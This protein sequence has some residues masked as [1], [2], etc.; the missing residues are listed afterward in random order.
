MYYL[1]EK[2]FD[3]VLFF[4][5]GSFFSSFL[6][7]DI[8]SLSLEREIAL[9]IG[10]SGGQKRWMKAMAGGEGRRWI[11]VV[12]GEYGAQRWRAEAA[13]K[14]G[15]RHRQGKAEGVSSLRRRHVEAAG[16]SGTRLRRGRLRWKEEGI[17]SCSI[18]LRRVA[19]GRPRWTAASDG[20]IGWLRWMA[21]AD[22]MTPGER[23]R[24]RE[25]MTKV[26]DKQCI[27]IYLL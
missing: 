16:D 6:Y 20:R 14:V 10:G 4:T 8:F 13:G 3:R 7:Y 12:V 1:F 2:F 25:R 24:E 27:K 5:R 23:S 17:L 18:R 11:A 21:A 26:Y 22:E 19:A 15:G 9:K